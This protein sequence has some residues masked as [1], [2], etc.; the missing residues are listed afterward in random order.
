M[1]YATHNRTRQL[2]LSIYYSTLSYWSFFI[3]SFLLTFGTQLSAYADYLRITCLRVTP[4]PRYFPLP[5]SSIKWL[6]HLMLFS[7]SYP[8]IRFSPSGSDEMIDAVCALV[9]AYDVCVLVMV[10]WFVMWALPSSPIN[11]AVAL[12][13]DA[14]VGLFDVVG[15]NI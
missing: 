1:D 13:L 12:E 15:A 3:A 6:M 14:L 8:F 2:V 4:F 7:Q 5:D 10:N 9:S 11:T